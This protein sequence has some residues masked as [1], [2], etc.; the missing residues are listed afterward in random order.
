MSTNN[1]FDAMI[2]QQT[3]HA[4]MQ[5]INDLGIRAIMREKVMEAGISK[6]DIRQMIKDA[7]DSYVRSVNITSIVAETVNNIIKKAVREEVK[8]QFSTGSYT[9]RPNSVTQK[10]IEEEVKKALYSNFSFNFSIE[11]RQQ[12]GQREEV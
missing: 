4:V 2:K 10:V 12:D 3:E 5:A 6:D 9:Y 1:S 7:I 11:R 8:E